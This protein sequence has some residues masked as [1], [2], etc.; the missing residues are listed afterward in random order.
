MK[1][2]FIYIIIS[3]YFVLALVFSQEQN[4]N[5]GTSVKTQVAFNPVLDS[6]SKK[7]DLVIAFRVVL[8]KTPDSNLNYM[9]FT[10]RFNHH[11]AYKL[12]KKLEELNLSDSSLS[13]FWSQIEQNEILNIKNERE[14]VDVCPKKY[15]IYFSHS[16]EFTIFT[17]TQNKV[18]TYY[19]PE[20]YDEVCPGMP[21]RKKIINTVAAIDLLLQK[22]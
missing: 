15:H 17:K 5:N 20:Y 6:L 12:N 14:L 21:E 8:D 3:I 7:N 4:I 2:L 22:D 19:Y 16:Y 18:I 10:K 9:V 13:L 1:S 11:Q